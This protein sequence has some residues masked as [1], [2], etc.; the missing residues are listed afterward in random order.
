MNKLD[1]S[2]VPSYSEENRKYLEGYGT[3]IPGVSNHEK[4]S[5]LFQKIKHDSFE[6]ADEMKVLRSEIYKNESV[7]RGMPEHVISG[8]FGQEM[9]EN[10]RNCLLDYYAGNK[11]MED[12]KNLFTECCNAM[13]E[14][15]TS[16]LQTTGYN[17]ADN[18]QIIGQ[19][20]EIFSKENQRAARA[21]NSAE[22]NAINKEYG[23]DSR[24]N[25]QKGYSYYN[26]FYYYEVE[27]MRDVFREMTGKMAQSWRIP[28][29]DTE[30][31]EKN[32][33]YT[34]DGSLDFNS[35]WNY[36]YRNNMSVS[37]IINENEVPPRDFKMFFNASKGDLQFAGILKVEIGGIT[38]KREV[39]FDS[40]DSDI[41]NISELIKIS[42]DDKEKQEIINK[43]LKNFEI[44]TPTYGTLTKL[45]S[46]WGNYQRKPL[47]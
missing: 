45:N 33:Q 20:F 8:E 6:K 16:S 40:K 35:G 13:R 17:E 1:L 28:E 46:V 38:I 22:G 2:S 4:H 30:K 21:A 37:S 11:T 5:H 9:K 19:I 34:L 43:F 42:M 24:G 36:L 23:G 12:I 14:Y 44:F 29:I 27:A 47:L 7:V 39:P 26:S 15:C 10:I 32:T 25:E 41:F 18:Q 31:I 3:V